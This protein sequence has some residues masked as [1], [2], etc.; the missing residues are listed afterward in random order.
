MNII[1]LV[2]AR[3]EADIIG[4]TVGDLLGQGI[5]VHL[6]D[7][8]S[9]DG[10]AAA[11]APHLRDGLLTIE[12]FSSTVS[13]GPDKSEPFCLT[14]IL[15]RKEALAAE[16]DGDWFINHDAD[17]FRESPWGWLT[18]RE[19]IELVDRL[20]YNAIDFELL[21][22][23]P[24]HDNYRPGD[25]V[26]AAFRYYEPGAAW[27]RVQIRCWKRSRAPVNL[28]G[29]AGHEAV[30]DNRRVFPIKFLLRHYP[31]RSRAHAERK[32]YQDRMPRFDPGERQQGWH[33]QYDHLPAGFDFIRSASDLTAF[34]PDAIRF[35]LQLAALDALE[36]ADHL[37]RALEAETQRRELLVQ[38]QRRL[39]ALATN[40]ERRRAAAE[41]ELAAALERSHALADE[42]AEVEAH[43][44]RL[45]NDLHGSLSW[46]ITAPLRRLHR[47][48]AVRRR[49]P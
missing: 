24:T 46:R 49:I 45:V 12:R 44:S 19:G 28:I 8:G 4:Q 38:E 47:L 11:L 13:G 39:E 5:R 30:F 10:T 23:W 1:A 9:T 20:G 18:L 22:F 2:A 16:L 48:L 42:R 27:D 40:L 21:N 32:V 36:R 3:N 34:D 43:W 14:A 26:R 17:E 29:S 37:K 33:V 41:A 15:A 35:R 25:D 7:H 6:L 31:F